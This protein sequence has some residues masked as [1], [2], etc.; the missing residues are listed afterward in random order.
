MQP[1]PS[2]ILRDQTEH[3]RGL[4]R[5][6]ID[7]LELLDGNWINAS[8]T[9]ALSDRQMEELIKLREDVRRNNHHR[10]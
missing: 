6:L 1:F 2:D 7:R 8:W 10:A 4:L 9:D 3:Y 5:T